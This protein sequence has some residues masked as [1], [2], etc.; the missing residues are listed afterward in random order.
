MTVLYAATGNHVARLD[1]SASGSW[2]STLL[3]RDLQV[4]CVAVDPRDGNRL[5]AGTFDDGLYRSLDAGNTWERVDDGIPHD[6]FPSVAFSPSRIAGG[7]SAVFAGTEPSS[8]YL[9]EDDGET[10]IDLHEL[11][12]LPSAPTWSFPPRPWTSHVRWIALSWHDPDLIFAGIELG[13][14]MRSIDG[15]ATWEDRKPGSYHDSHC[16]RTHPT[17]STRIYEAA[18]GGVATS[19]D[20]GDTWTPI[21]EGMDR[22]YVWALAVDPSDPERWFVSASHSARY[23]HRDDDSSEALIYRK[24]GT[25]PWEPLSGGLDSPMSEMPYALVIP[26]DQPSTIF[27]GTRQGSLLISE[28]SGDSWHKTEIE[29]DGIQGLVVAP[30][31]WFES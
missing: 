3:L 29:L 6:R 8:L 13:G 2:T 23:A 7:R 21:D 22:H 5:Y 24:V 11:R 27:A 26:E 19:F 28:D 20:A 31:S 14:V 9:S 17:D 4:Q 15:G 30:G 12:D 16:I 1:R 18:G 25:D 10:W